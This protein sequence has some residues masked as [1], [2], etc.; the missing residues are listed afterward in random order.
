MLKTAGKAVRSS[1][2]LLLASIL[3]A[4]VG[5]TATTTSTTT[6]TTSTTT[7]TVATTTVATT[8]TTMAP[9]TV[10]PSL[11][12]AES[13]SLVP[14]SDVGAGW[15]LAL[16]SGSVYPESG[17]T[18]LYLVS[19]DGILYEILAWEAYEPAPLVIDDWS[20]VQERALLRYGGFP[21]LHKGIRL[22]SLESGDE[23]SLIVVPESSEISARLT[24]PTGSN[25][26]KYLDDGSEETLEVLYPDGAV[27]SLLTS[28]PSDS[29]VPLTWLSSAAGS[30]VVIGDADGLHVFSI[31]G[32][33]LS[34]LDAPGEGCRPASWWDEE[35]ILA[36]CIPRR[37]A[38]AGGV[39]RQLWL[40]PLDGGV[41]LNLTSVPASPGEDDFG[42]LDAWR[43]GD[44]VY[45][46]WTG[47]CSEAR[48][49]LLYGG[50]VL[51]VQAEGQQQIIGVEGANLMLHM[52]D[53]CDELHGNVRLVSPD[54]EVLA[55]L[56]PR[57]EGVY[58]VVSAVMAG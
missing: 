14:W 55:T 2:A 6:T 58:G 41:A 34:D 47:G 39:Y 1:W 18:V 17:P 16:Y 50:G 13:R 42:Y 33:R 35:T 48:V 29:L 44:Q 21:N 40:V 25:I 23:T 30:P 56:F 15:V 53:G 4:C 57:F 12:A 27:Y 38:N 36:S 31:R 52:W 19:P 26:L 51:P 11:P 37:V 28:Q 9:V 3:G 54:G 32:D 8:T 7:T 46:Q 22:L 10:F 45:M 5:A 43:A 20:P 49:D 24:E